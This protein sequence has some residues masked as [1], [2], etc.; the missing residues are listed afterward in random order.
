MTTLKERREKWKPREK[1]TPAMRQERSRAKARAKSPKA[2][3]KKRV[4][5]EAL[6]TQIGKENT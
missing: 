2:N 4:K 5:R 6:K 1:L 3:E